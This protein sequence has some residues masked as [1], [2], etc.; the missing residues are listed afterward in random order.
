VQD[1]IHGQARELEARLQAQLRLNRDLEARLLEQQRRNSELAQS[2]ARVLDGISDA[3][4]SLDRQWRFEYVN[5]KAAATFGRTPGQLLGRTIWEEFPQ[6]VG[7]PFHHAYRKAMQERTTV[8]VEDQYAPQ[9]RWFENRI[10]PTEE[11][12]SV[13]VTEI[14]DRK[15]AERALEAS[16]TQMAQQLSELE[17]L[18]R[19][20][21]IGLSLMDRDLRFV[22]INE[23][24]AA[25][26]GRPAAEHI[27]RSLDEMVPAL[28]GELR[29]L[30]QRVLDTGQP[31][32]DVEIS[33]RNP[34]DPDS[35]AYWVASYLPVRGQDGEVA[36]VS[37]V[38]ADVTDL[39]SARMRLNEAQ[40]IGRIGDWEYTLETGRIFWSSQLYELYG[41]DPGTGPPSYGEV[42]A[43]LDERS[44]QTMESRLSDL[45]SS[46]RP[47]EYEVC[48]QLP[49]GRTAQQ[50][51]VAV[52]VFDDDG[53]VV[54]AH[55]IVQDITQRKRAEAALARSEQ[56]WRLVM[57]GLGRH[58]FV[59]LLDLHGVVLLANRPSRD[60]ASL[61]EDEVLGLPVEDTYWFAY[62][63]EVRQRLRDA[64]RR[65]A[66]G[67]EVR[68][69]ERIRV[70]EGQL[71]WL[72]FSVHP[73]RDET[74]AV[75]LLVPSAIVIDE[76]K[77]AEQQLRE[78]AR[79]QR[80]LS[81][82]LVQ[83]QETERRRI[84]AELHDRIGQDLTA[85]G[86]HLNLIGRSADDPQA[87]A[88]RLG[89]SRSL[90]EN[91]I[92]SLR[93]LIT[94]LRPPALEDYGLLAGLR[95]YGELVASRAGIEIAVHGE[96]PDPRPPAPV[97]TALFR[98]AQEALVNATKHAQAR[99]VD[100]ALRS[101]AGD[102]ALEIVDD[103]T[104]FDPALLQQSGP[105]AHWGLE[106]MRE[107]AEAVGARL[108][109]ESAPGHGT[110]IVVEVGPTP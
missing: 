35:Q 25:I 27:G 26:N 82:R 5:E 30:C 79:R 3:F 91:T 59:G 81:W 29:T 56:Q 40:R 60:A 41:R 38:V 61:G 69:D 16:R 55:G 46:G 45:V 37:A 103:G 43:Y 50:A 65:A 75:V 28:S 107:R 1:P 9:D 96:D 66:Q 101:H 13:F 15:R 89:D 63:D 67:E 47:Q 80:A 62:S 48:V 102:L 23:R 109:L 95:W 31:V 77:R 92:A 24:L 52:P 100:L 32:M 19:T 73:L 22:R 12:I 87:A 76:R 98:I 53:R 64:V 70:A 7:Q 110:R 11:G 72:D 57:D 68:Y 33:G 94:E 90:L 4:L 88:E 2:H 42:L 58:M 104:G 93:S 44:R 105:R 86:I 78:A 21:P 10:Y 14:T 17:Q 8:F 85:L 74:G 49:D 36:G 6:L 83:A 34:A 54:R 18:Y 106:M 97:E 20:A 99:R 84:S 71:L 39:K 51:V 108:R